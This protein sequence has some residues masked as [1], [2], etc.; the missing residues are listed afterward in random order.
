MIDRDLKDLCPELQVL[1]PIFITKCAT[2]GITVKAI[3][4]YR[5]PAEQ[6]KVKSQGLSNAPAGQSPHNH[7]D[8]DGKPC[9]LAFDFAIFDHGGYVMDGTDRRYAQAGA[10]AKGL[11]LEWGGDFISPH[12]GKPKPDWD[13]VQISNWRS[14]HFDISKAEIS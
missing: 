9:S 14:L 11:G 12:T 5:S 3:V 2:A 1:A 13:H 8:P 7:L 4:T 10:I 6:N